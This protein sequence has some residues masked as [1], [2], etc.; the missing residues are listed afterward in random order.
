MA[1]SRGVLGQWRSRMTFVLALSASAVG[2]GNLWRFPYLMGENG[3]GTFM[4]A[5]VACLFLI[6]VPILIA[7][8]MVGSHGRGSPPVALLWSADRSLRSRAWVG[9][10]LLSCLAGLLLLAVYAVVAGWSLAFAAA[11][12]RGEFAAAST[13]EV[14]RFFRLLVS[15]GGA[16][17]AWT[18]L[19][20]V[21]VVGVVSLGIR[22]GIGVV[23]WL[24]VPAILALM[25]ILVDLSLTRGD[26]VAAQAFLFSFQTLDFD[27]S[28]VLAALG[29]AFYTLGIGVGV[30]ITYGAYSDERI[31][32]ARSVLAV[33]VFDTTLA[34]LA[35]VALYPLVFAANVEPG[36]GPGLTFVAMPYVFGNLAD[37]E[38]YG[39]AF[40]LLVLVVA[41]G[42][43][44]ALL[45]PVVGALK[46]HLKIRRL[47]AAV[48]A[49]GA[50]WSLS[51]LAVYSLAS[52]EG[53]AWFL[54][55]DRLATQW[56]MPLAA[57]GVA[58]FVGWQMQPV[59]RR[60]QLYRAGPLLYGAWLFLLRYLAVPAIMVI[61]LVNLVRN[62]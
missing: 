61:L 13:L 54:I 15:D 40:F 57:L 44:V 25:L 51:A 39:T 4:L 18:S 28:S 19:F 55:M 50:V 6:A 53:T 48:I 1:L 58:C 20:L 8:V 29:H 41:L 24:A 23:V 42:S 36:M 16:A 26:L 12:A 37:G 9:V 62:A 2:L 21:V 33:A 27:Q 22:R 5:Y 35:G 56:L 46:Q 14:G 30:G 17:L 60:E 59:L 45:E 49:G 3:G 31:P 38:L 52:S 47:T 43:A 11:M 7:E 10:G 34:V 32:I